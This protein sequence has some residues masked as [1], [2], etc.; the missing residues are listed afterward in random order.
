MHRDRQQHGRRHPVRA[1]LSEPD[2]AVELA[3]ASEE[4]HAQGGHSIRWATMELDTSFAWTRG[5]PD[6]CHVAGRL[7]HAAPSQDAQRFAAPRVLR[8]PRYSRSA[9]VMDGKPIS[10]QG[11]ASLGNQ[12]TSATSLRADG[13]P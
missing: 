2:I 7:R 3:L 4:S 10:L 1:D 6:A 9:R 11:M 12:R 5:R 8:R 13:L